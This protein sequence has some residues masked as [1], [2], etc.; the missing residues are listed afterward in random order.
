MKR[1]AGWIA[2]AL[3]VLIGWRSSSATPSDGLSRR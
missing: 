3:A 1:I 2:A